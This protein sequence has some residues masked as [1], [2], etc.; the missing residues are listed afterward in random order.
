MRRTISGMV[1]AICTLM[2]LMVSTFARPTNSSHDP[3]AQNQLPSELSLCGLSKDIELYQNKVVRVRVAIVGMGGHYPFFVTASGCHPDKLIVLHVKFH[4]RERRG[5]M[6]QKRIDEV[7]RF[8]LA[9]G[10]RRAEAIIVGRVKKK[11]CNGCPSPELLISVMD[12]ELKMPESNG[13]E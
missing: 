8:N 7:L 10:N 13:G 2:M 12:V 3:I 5:A 11:S 9:N 6:L 4:H 1:V